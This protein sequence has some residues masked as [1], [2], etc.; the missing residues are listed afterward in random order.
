MKKLFLS[1]PYQDQDIANQ[2]SHMLQQSGF[3]VWLFTEKV[4]SAWLTRDAYN[5]EDRAA[6]IQDGIEQSDVFLVLISEHTR[7]SNGVRNEIAYARLRGKPTI[8]IM[9]RPAD[10]PLDLLEYQL[11][12]WSDGGLLAGVQRLIDYLSN[13]FVDFGGPSRQDKQ[14]ALPTIAQLDTDRKRVL[15]EDRVIRVFIAYSR[16]QRSIA[17]Q[18]SDLLT[19]YGKPNFYDA[20]IKAGAAWRQTIQQALDDATHLVVIW[21][22]EAATS[23]EVE[24]E[25]SYALAEGK[26]IVPVLAKDVPKLPYHL[27]G[28]QYIVLESDM[29]RLEG[30]LL[31]ALEK[32]SGTEDIWN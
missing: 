4:P 10:I 9:I 17:S 32:S 1:Y 18:V 20:K 14:F 12:D 19:R 28:L 30:P 6:R 11:L 8:P 31:A 27:H 24:R 2:V 7:T 21:T 3:D 15:Q 13:A 5:I 16:I 25:V 29:T 26:I 22:K 23:D